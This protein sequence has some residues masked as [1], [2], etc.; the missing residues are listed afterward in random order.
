MKK[1]PEDQRLFFTI[2]NISDKPDA[3]TVNLLLCSGF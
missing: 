3:L 2:E 1:P